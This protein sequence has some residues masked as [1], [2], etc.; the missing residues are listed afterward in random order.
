MST[1]IRKPSPLNPYNVTP[2]KPRYSTPLKTPLTRFAGG[3]GASS[4]AST[5]STPMSSPTN[6]TPKRKRFIRKQPLKD[7]SVGFYKAGTASNTH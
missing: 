6:S 1:P 4:P 5:A 3:V 2:S 7:R